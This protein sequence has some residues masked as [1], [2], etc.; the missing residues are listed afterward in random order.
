MAT[1]IDV[2]HDALK[3]QFGSA[4]LAAD[5]TALD[6][7]IQVAPEGLPAIAAFLRDSPQWQMEML[8]CITGVDYWQAGTAATNVDWQPHIELLYHLSSLAHRRRLVLK[9][10]LPRWQ[11]DIEGQL[12]EVPTVSHI[13]RT[14]EWHEREVFDLIGVRFVGHPDLRR[15]LCPEDWVGHPLRKDYRAPAEYRGIPAA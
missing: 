8:N 3:S 6:P 7:W 15:I 12:P 10:V 1:E 11:S 2:L 14:A 13:W 9:V 4:I 5:T